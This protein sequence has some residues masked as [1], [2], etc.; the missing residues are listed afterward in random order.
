MSAEL[1]P[2]I[3]YIGAGWTERVQIP[4]FTLGGLIPQAIASGQ[5]PNA[6][7]VAEKF[8]IPEVY[9]DWRELVNSPNVEIV[10][11]CTPPW[12][13]KEMAIAALEAGK[14]VI[15]EK[16]MALSLEDARAVADLAEQRAAAVQI[17]FMRRFDP[18]YAAG[19]RRIAAGEIGAVETF[20]ALSRDT[21]PPSPQF[22]RSSGGIFL[23]MAIHDFDLAR[24]LVGEV[25]EVQS[26]GS[27]LIDP[28]FAE[29]GDVDTAATLL[30]FAG[31]A[32]GVVETARRSAWGY[33]IRTEVAGARGKL[34]IEAAQKTP[35][36]FSRRFGF[37][38][39]HYESFP[40]RFA[41]AYR[42]QFEA[43]V[44]ALQMGKTPTPGP[45]D[46]L[47]ALR[48][49]L[50]VRRS[51]HEGRPVRLSEINDVNVV[52]N[53]GPIRSPVVISEDAQFRKAAD[54]HLADERRAGVLIHLN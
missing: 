54:R 27:V 3:G 7:R 23:D 43:F 16:P 31:G 2:R 51:L 36:L 39:D 29:A 49:A 34:V 8:N 20:R 1:S 25:E 28:A 46:A 40:D 14:H 44:T 35:L 15:C 13:H 18:G 52:A 26:W 41:E 22:I 10:S 48:I 9:G 50:A 21:H 30:R 17:G 53:A 19:Q 47:A 42:N 38:G 24:F 37:E 32:L 12:L 5:R 6:E 45:R 4:A 11:I 33:D